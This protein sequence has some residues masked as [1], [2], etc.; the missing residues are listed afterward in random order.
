MTAAVA[1][2]IDE[3]RATF[4]EAAVTVRED[5]QGGAYVTVE[6]VDPGPLY[7]QDETWIAFHVTFQYPYADVYPHFVRPD[8]VR[9]DGQPLGAGMG[10]GAFDGRPAIQLSRRSNRLDPASDTAAMKLLKVLRWL[11]EL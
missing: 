1:G 10:M 5:E 4:P 8:L 3:L 11:A 2:A 6:P 7:V 9:N